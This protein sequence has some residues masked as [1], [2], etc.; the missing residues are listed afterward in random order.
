VC[1]VPQKQK[2][3]RVQKPSNIGSSRAG[4]GE[5]DGV[6]MVV[7]M[8]MMMGLVVVLLLLQPHF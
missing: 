3:I 8:V 1:F 5:G 6:L 7:V 4:N 2:I